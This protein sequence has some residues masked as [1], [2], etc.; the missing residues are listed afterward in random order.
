VTTV[1]VAVVDVTSFFP[2]VVLTRAVD[3]GIIVVAPSPIDIPMVAPATLELK[4]VTGVVVVGSVVDVS[5]VVI[6]LIVR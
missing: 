2:S 6:S 1:V 5:P 3:V 4:V